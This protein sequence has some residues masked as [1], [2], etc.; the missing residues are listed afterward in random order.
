[1]TAE[2][3]DA[4]PTDLAAAH[5][6]ILAQRA[7]L[8]A[9]EA[10]AAS[11]ENEARNRAL[12]IEQLKQTIAKLR[13]ERFGQSAERRALL[14]QLELQLFELEEDEAQAAAAAEMKAAAAQTIPVQPFTRRKPA[15]RPL[16][17][18]LPRERIVYPIP[19]ACPCCGG[20]LHKLGEDVTEMLE[21]VPRQWKVIQHVREKY[22][23]R[24]CEPSSNRKYSSTVIVRSSDVSRMPSRYARPR[25]ARNPT[26]ARDVVRAR[27]E[28][29]GGGS[30][31]VAPK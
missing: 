19:G 3:T 16:P 29:S 21:L 17:E 18:H 22:S 13:H 30:M 28:L 20:T 9:A 24:T 2:L 31:L 1:M 7:A 15:R 6:L 12:Q 4:L 25:R 8:R 14:H 26:T 5:A 11:A 27:V 10:R 23:C